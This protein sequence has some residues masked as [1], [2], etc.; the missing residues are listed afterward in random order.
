[1]IEAIAP[2]E[3]MSRD[4]RPVLKAFATGADGDGGGAGSER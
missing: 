3:K 4:L 2:L 1:M